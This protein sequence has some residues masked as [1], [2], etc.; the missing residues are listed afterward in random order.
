MMAG[1]ISMIANMAQW[2]MI[3]GGGAR[4]RDDGAKWNAG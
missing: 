3:F 4:D 1:A 2:A